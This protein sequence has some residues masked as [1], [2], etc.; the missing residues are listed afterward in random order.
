MENPYR[1]PE[2]DSVSPARGAVL[3]IERRASWAVGR[4]RLLAI[5]LLAQ[6]ILESIVGLV[7]LSAGTLVLITYSQPNVQPPAGTS[8]QQMTIVFFGLA[9]VLLIPAGLHIWAGIANLSFRGYTLGLVALG[10][11]SIA[12][13]SGICAPTGLPLMVYGLIVYLQPDV[14]DAFQLGEE[15]QSPEAILE[16]YR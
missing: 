9:A 5:L 14:A 15:G 4:V 10:G 11:T 8:P 13:F 3:P 1:A 16:A 2:V 6:G 7:S 12:L